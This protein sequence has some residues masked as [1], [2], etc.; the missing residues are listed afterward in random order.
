MDEPPEELPDL[1]AEWREVTDRQSTRERVYAV[2]LQLYEPTPV[3][4]AA[5]RADVSPETAREYLRW[6]DEIGI[7][8]GVGESPETFVRNEAYFRWRRV[9]RLRDLPAEELERRLER[10]TE[11][12]REYRR[13][14]DATH[15]DDVDALDHADYDDVESV[16]QDVSAWQ[17][18]RRRIRELER[19]RQERDE[20]GATPA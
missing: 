6:F 14:Y 3:R 1:A 18:V 19:A 12:E 4:E 17:T 7:V 10:L 11:R 9:Q 13:T 8:E 2:A 5:D 15:P 20:R 16:W